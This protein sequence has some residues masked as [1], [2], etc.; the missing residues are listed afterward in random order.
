MEVTQIK[1]D[2]HIRLA[3]GRIATLSAVQFS[4]GLYEVMLLLN[5]DEGEEITSCQCHDVEETLY[6]FDEI[7]ARHHVPELTGKYKKL[8]EDLRNALAYGRANQGTDD[9]GSSNF[10]APAVSLPGWDKALV[11]AA[12]KTAGT[13]CFEWQLGRSTSYLFSIPGVGQGYTRTKAAEAMSGYM[14]AQGYDAGMY[15]QMD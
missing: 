9:G 12:A 14:A 10:D 5:D 3:D 8:A 7:R 1:R 13:M 6:A 15:Y 2:E 11:E 4:D